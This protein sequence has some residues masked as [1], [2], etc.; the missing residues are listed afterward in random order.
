MADLAVCEVALRARLKLLEQLLFVAKILH[1]LLMVLQH[2]RDQLV[3]LSELLLDEPHMLL[4][5]RLQAAQLT[6][7]STAWRQP[8]HDCQ[9]LAW[10]LRILQ[11]ATG[12]AKLYKARVR[13][14][15]C[16]QTRRS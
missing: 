4:C 5:A 16:Q 2:L 7:M 15:S 1:H 6:P 11:A 9:E 13:A 3:S 8:Q 10:P 14:R 12:S